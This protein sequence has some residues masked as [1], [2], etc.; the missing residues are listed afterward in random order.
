M[1]TWIDANF[2]TYFLNSVII[3]TVDAL[4]MIVIASAA[5]YALTFLK[6]PG[7]PLIYAL[8]WLG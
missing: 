6:F 3:S 7:K 5:A 2:N 4:V 1:T 8:L